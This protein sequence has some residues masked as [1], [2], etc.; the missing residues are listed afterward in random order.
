MRDLVV[1]GERRVDGGAPAHH[2]GEHSGDDQVA[3][4]DAQ[5]AAHQRVDA[6]TMATRK[7]IAADG[8]QRRDPLEDDLESEE[9]ERARHVVAVGQERPV[10][11]VDLLLLLHPADGEDHVLRLAGEQVAAARAAVGEQPDAGRVPSLDLR[12]VRRRR[13][14]HHRSG[15]LLDPAEGGNV[16]VGSQQ[17]PRLAG[18]RLR[19]EIGLPLGQTV[20]VLGQPAAIVGALPSRIA[21]RSTGSA[22]PSISKDDPGTWVSAMTPCRRAM[23][24]AMRSEYVSSEPTRTASPTLTA[25]TTRDARAPSRSRRHGGSRRSAR[26]SGEGWPRRR[27]GRSTKPSTSVSG[28]RRAASTGGM[29]AFNAAAIA[30]TSSAPQKPSM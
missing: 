14:R 21:R 15:L 23:R 3:H 8:T 24:C 17:D 1:A 2:V 28:N 5:R 26:R 25:A 4:E 18:T 6:A 13:A 22:S 9:H 20:R 7:H 16:L 12:T 11:R 10:A 27:A 29:T 30:A 19:G